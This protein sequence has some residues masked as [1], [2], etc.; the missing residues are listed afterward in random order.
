MGLS[1]ISISSSLTNLKLG[2]GLGAI[3]VGLGKVETL[4]S[5]RTWPIDGRFLSK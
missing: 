2:I 3:L 1:I 5:I 4:S